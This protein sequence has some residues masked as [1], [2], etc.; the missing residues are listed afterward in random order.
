VHRGIVILRNL[1]VLLI[2]PKPPKPGSKELV[3]AMKKE[4]TVSIVEA[5]VKE[6]IAR[7]EKGGPVMENAIEFVVALRHAGD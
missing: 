2:Q 1:A 5:V 4:G 3:E 6:R 7:G